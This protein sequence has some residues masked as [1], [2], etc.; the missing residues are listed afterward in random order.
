MFLSVWDFSAIAPIVIAS[1]GI[2]SDIFGENLDL[3]RKDSTFVHHKGFL[4]STSK[5]LHAI[6]I[7]TFKPYAKDFS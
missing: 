7:D 2:V 4:F 1:G 6:V 5:E 3:N